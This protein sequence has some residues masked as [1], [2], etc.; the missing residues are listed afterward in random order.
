MK[1]NIIIVIL[2]L[3]IV[4]PLITWY[5]ITLQYY[6]E[7]S[8]ILEKEREEER[9][10]SRYEAQQKEA[11]VESGF[12]EGSLDAEEFH[13]E[14]DDDRSAFYEK[15]KGKRLSIVGPVESISSDEL[16]FKHDERF[17]FGISCYYEEENYDFIEFGRGD[18][19]KVE[20]YVRI[21]DVNVVVLSL[22]SCKVIEAREAR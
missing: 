21:K 14:F 4:V 8:R 2:S 1:K 11:M 17:V 5:F 10:I 9:I 20:A 18:F 16:E 15:Y 19:I 13:R 12:Y 6:R 7:D 22:Y 3:I